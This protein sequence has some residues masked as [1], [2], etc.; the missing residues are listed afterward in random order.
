MISKEI[1]VTIVE[2]NRRSKDAGN[3]DYTLQVLENVSHKE[4]FVNCFIEA[5]SEAQSNNFCEE[6]GLGETERDILIMMMKH[7][8]G[9]VANAFI[10]QKEIE[11]LEN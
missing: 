10:S 9:I 7:I 6:F 4:P 3:H 5:V 2:Q 8:G 11:E 1:M